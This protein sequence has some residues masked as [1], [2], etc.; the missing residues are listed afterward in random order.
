MRVST[1]STVQGQD[2]DAK[3]KQACQ[4]FEAIFYRMLLK[5]MRK[6][7]PQGGLINR[8]LS[9]E[10]YETLLDEKLADE[11]AKRGDL[12]IGK[13]LYEQ[14]SGRPHQPVKAR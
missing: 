6:T 12:G 7:V 11:F 9:T 5:E 8:G 3:L 4:E 1:A 13:A 10:V 14:L 2:F